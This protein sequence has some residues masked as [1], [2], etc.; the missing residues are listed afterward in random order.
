MINVQ[1]CSLRVYV[2]WRWTF[3]SES[4]V[5]QIIDLLSVEEMQLGASQMPEAVGGWVFRVKPHT[6]VESG[7]STF[8]ELDS[9]QR[10]PPLKSQP[11]K[12][13]FWYKLKANSSFLVCYNLNSRFVTAIGKWSNHT[14]VLYLKFLKI[15]SRSPAKKRLKSAKN[16]AL[17]SVYSCHFNTSFSSFVVW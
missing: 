8:M 16:V 13:D 2:I 15:C 9:I 12:D 6:L 7:S 1:N 11:P 4:S 5:S 17:L 14:T 10:W 3:Y